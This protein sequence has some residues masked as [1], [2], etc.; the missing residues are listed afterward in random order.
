V[1]RG[2]FSSRGGIRLTAQAG[3]PE[4]AREPLTLGDR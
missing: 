2:D 3:Y 4:P 1:V